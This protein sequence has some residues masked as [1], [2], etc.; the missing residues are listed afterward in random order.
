MMWFRIYTGRTNYLWFLFKLKKN[1]F[2]KKKEI[3][4]LMHPL[5]YVVKFAKKQNVK[6]VS[7]FAGGPKEEK[8]FIFVLDADF[9]RFT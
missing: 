5:Q 1:I 3:F 2:I 6:N 7:L 8:T 9:S 4:F